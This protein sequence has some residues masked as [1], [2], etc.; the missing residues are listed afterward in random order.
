MKNKS[1]IISIIAV[2]SALGAGYM[3]PKSNPKTETATEKNN[4]TEERQEPSDIVE[5]NDNDAKAAGI[6]TAKVNFGTGNEI[7]ILGR[8]MA[9][10]E[11]KIMVGAP[12]SGRV[13]R[14]YVAAGS[15]V[16]KGAPLFEIISAEGAGIVAD[17][18]AANA[19]VNMASAAAN[20]AKVA[21]A[22]DKF[23]Y[24][25]GVISRRELEN[26]LANSVSANANV[27]SQSAYASAARAKI[28]A[29]GAPSANGAIIIRTPITGIVN[30]MPISVGGF[31]P[32]GTIAGEITNV[33]NTEAVFQIAPN[34]LEKVAI[35]QSVNIETNDGKQLNATIKAIAPGAEAGA[36]SAI[37]RA[38][39][40]GANLAVGTVI[41]AQII[42]QNGAQNLRPIV[43]N[44]AINSIGDA[45]KVFVKTDKGYRAVSVIIGNSF[46]GQTEIISG[47]KGD[48]II[49]IKNAFLLKSQLAKSEL[50]EE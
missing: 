44:D 50:E 13:S 42:L 22:S 39:I 15:L 8:I 38:K 11:A 31:V 5:I 46:S 18:H 43:P 16:N 26:S 4:K 49:V 1:Y 40:D 2:I 9:A 14:V 10:P 27:A 23:L 36:N 28:G 48:E 32:Q 17:A 21:Y 3:L 25:K 20:A 45:K 41:N 35:G 24:S 7:R 33:D 6:E 47:L 34:L 30:N 12:I 37:I 19:N 29:A